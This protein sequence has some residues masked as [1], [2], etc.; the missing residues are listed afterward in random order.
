M[1]WMILRE[2]LLCGLWFD[3]LNVLVILFVEKE[4]LCGSWLCEVGMGIV[5]VIVGIDVIC[6][7]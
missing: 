2:R 4:L 6:E 5:L 3:V 1:V 7:S